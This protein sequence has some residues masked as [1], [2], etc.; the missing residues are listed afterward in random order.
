MRYLMKIFSKKEEGARTP[1]LVVCRRSCSE[2]GSD[3]LPE[4]HAR[5]GDMADLAI[6]PFTSLRDRVSGCGDG[7]YA[8]GLVGRDVVALH[9]G[10]AVEDLDCRPDIIG[11]KTHD[12]V[13]VT[14]AL[15][16]RTGDCE[17]RAG[18]TALLGRRNAEK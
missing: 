4:T 18:F 14:R 3:I 16:I 1:P 12:H 11:R 15:R 2:T 5:K 17:N 10:V 6:C 7:E 8:T 9:S 13:V